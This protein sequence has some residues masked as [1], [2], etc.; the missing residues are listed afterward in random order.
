M[1]RMRRAV[2]RAPGYEAATFHEPDETHPGEWLVVYRFASTVDLERWMDSPARRTLVEEGERLIVGAP[3]EQR[4]VEPRTDT[5]TLVSGVR[6]RPGREA[7]HRALHEACVDAARAMGG[8]E[9]A[10]LLPAL[11]DAQPETLATL[12]FSGQDELER[13]LRSPERRHCLDAMAPLAEGDRTVNVVGGFAGWFPESRAGGPRRW[14][15]AV[16]V[17]GGLAPVAIVVTLL[18]EA[19]LPDLPFVLAVLLGTVANVVILT[20]LVMPAIT[21]VLGGWLSR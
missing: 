14:K 7:E 19:L 2:T 5:V 4:I 6:L 17:L 15:Q 13:W 21:R 18:R 3:V 1:Q 9:R 8:L 12:T 11:G 16:A 20:W 10:E